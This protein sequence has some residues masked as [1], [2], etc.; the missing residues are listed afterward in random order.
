MTVQCSQDT[1]RIGYRSLLFLGL[2]LFSAWVGSAPAKLSTAE[3]RYVQTPQERV[4]D[5]LIEAVKQA[6][7][8]A[9]TRGRVIEINYDVDD[10]VE[11]PIS[12]DILLERVGKLLKKKR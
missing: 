8:S 10:Y 6:T 12:P 11:K 2:T 9:Q 4:L 5:A 7:V 1:N 3:V